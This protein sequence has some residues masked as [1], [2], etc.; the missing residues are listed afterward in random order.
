VHD[1]LL[2]TALRRAGPLLVLSLVAAAFAFIYT[3]SERFFYFWDYALYQDLTANTAAAFRTSFSD[4]MHTVWGSFD[5]DYNRLFTLPLVPVALEFGLSRPVFIVCLAIFYQ[6]PFALAM[7]AI[8]A[9]L[10]RGCRRP[11][12]WGTALLT[13][14]LPTIWAPTLRGYPDAGGAAFILIAAWLYI[15]NAHGRRGHWRVALIGVAL[16]CAMLFRRHYIH[17]GIA[18]FAAG[19]I[20]RTA[21][22]FLSGVKSSSRGALFWQAVL[23]W[24]VIGAATAGT[25]LIVGPEF[26]KYALALNYYELYR[27][28]LLAPMDEFRQFRDLFGSGVWVLSFCGW[29]LAWRAKVLLR[30]PAF[31][32][33]LFGSLSLLIWVFVVRQWGSHYGFHVTIL[34][35]PG[36]SALGVVASEHVRGVTMRRLA[37]W[38]A[39]AV[40][41]GLNL[42]LSFSTGPKFAASPARKLFA[43]RYPPFVRGDYAEILRLL[44]HLRSIAGPEDPIYVG[45]SSE[46]INF[47]LLIH[48]ERAHRKRGQVPLLF[49][50]P[51][52]VDS[53]DW[54]PVE[55]LIKARFV[56]IATPF[57]HHLPPSEQELVRVVD[58]AFTEGWEVARDFVALPERFHLAERV[59]PERRV[60]VTVF[61][62]TRPTTVPTALRLLDAQQ[63][64]LG[65]Q[66]LGPHPDW[67]ALTPE[68]EWTRPR[69][70]TLRV[71]FAPERPSPQTFLYVGAA[72]WHEKRFTASLR[73]VSSSA[74][75]VRMTLSAVD[76]TGKRDDMALVTQVVSPAAGS[77]EG[78]VSIE[79][80][81][82]DP[83]CPGL[84]L[85]VAPQNSA[86]LTLEL[87][88][89]SWRSP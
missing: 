32:V 13:L 14:L 5:N 4:G 57:Q 31:F 69:R 33:F 77:R 26:V 73:F 43:A 28:Y 51:P 45:G 6:L 18:F 72:D 74:A 85:A 27:S 84:L 20:H 21:V 15:R 11:I 34:L 9:E 29:L 71:R 8:A 7:G 17:A 89:L 80:P 50:Q 30:E 12:L 78:M 56:I 3:T 48:A 76:A 66:P 22:I 88:N 82:R 55:E 37:L 19:C 24:T 53:R 36:L 68:S 60:E 63:R 67:I 61:G 87:A 65:P 40:F 2:A 47:D 49:L 46:T 35:V 10:F 23:E 83:Q 54:Y 42:F 75:P 1:G 79:T 39:A 64:F 86:M 41:L 58:A 81:R 59:H 25:L 38:S 62:R 70:E 16:G 52:Q 44:E